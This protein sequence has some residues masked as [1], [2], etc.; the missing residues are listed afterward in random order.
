[1]IRCVVEVVFPDRPVP[2]RRRSL[3]ELGP[4]EV[5]DE[6]VDGTVLLADAVGKR[7]HLCDVEVVHLD[8]DA[9]ATQ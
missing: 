9:D 1:V 2:R 6:D 8:R 4:P 5:V 3:E 7:P